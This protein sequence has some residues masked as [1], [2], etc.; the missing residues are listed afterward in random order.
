MKVLWFSNTPANADEYFDSELKGTGG[1]LKA[2]DQALQNQ[3]ELHIAFQ[4]QHDAAF[5]YKAT[6]YHPIKTDQSLFSKVLNRFRSY[7][8]DKEDLNKYLE[9]INKLKPDI[10]HIHGTE[11]PFACIIPHINI[12]VVVSIQGNI[13][14]CLHKFCCGFENQYLHVTDRKTTSLKKLFFPQSFANS[15]K[16]FKKMYRREERNLGLTK[17]IIGRTAW[18]KRITSIL[19]TDSIY[20]H[21]D[22]ILRDSFYH[23]QWSPHFSD[24][25]I[26][27]TTNGNDFYKGFETLCMT[28][29]VLNNIGIDCEWRVAGIS[30]ADLIVK[31]TKQKLKNQYPQKGLVLMGSINEIT[32][33]ESLLSAD[34]Y[35]MTSHIENSP[36]NL[37]EAMILGLPCISTFVGGV[38]SLL[39]DGEEGILIQDGDPWA[40][41]GAIL[42]MANNKERAMQLGKKARKIALKRHDKD[43]IVNDLIKVYES[44]ISTRAGDRV[45]SK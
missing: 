31:V 15:Y 11:N 42:E 33:I 43:R 19:A 22:E 8:A 23:N 45:V 26:I 36:N 17:N 5:K 18:D 21:G 39:Q 16:L 14:V 9:I 32:L 7:V 25:I 20:Y 2:L 6:V 35:I 34:M 28:L 41:A 30:S 3:V 13:T 44:I 10:I 40:M 1:W 29:H 24:K 4:K 12:P 37:S 27:N 38:G